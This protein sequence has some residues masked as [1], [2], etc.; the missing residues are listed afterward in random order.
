M[1]DAERCVQVSG[2]WRCKEA[3]LQPLCQR[4]QELVGKLAVCR[5]QWIPRAANAA[6]DALANRA[7]DERRSFSFPG[8]PDR[9]AV[10]AA[11][12]KRLAD[13]DGHDGNGGEAPPEEED[14]LPAAKARRKHARRAGRDGN[15]Q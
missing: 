4:A 11:G 9:E 7:M 8:D 3:H 2:S 12:R 1:K 10:A 15:G 13:C 5:F 14:V 6:A